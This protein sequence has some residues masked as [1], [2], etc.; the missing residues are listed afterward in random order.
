MS[1][2]YTVYNLRLDMDSDLHAGG[3]SSL[4]NFYNTLDKGRREL[5][6]NVRPEE[7]IRT[8]YL[9]QALYP[10]VDRYAVPEDMKY[11]DIIQLHKL[12][13]YRNVDTMDHP[14]QLVF[15]RRFDQKRGGAKNVMSI[16]YENGVKYARVFSPAG[17]RNDFEYRL[18][19]DCNSLTDN[20]SWNVGGNVVNLRLDE[21]NYVVKTGSLSFDINNSSTTGFLEN[22]TLDHFS[23]KDFLQKGAAFTWLDLPLPQEMISIKL[24]LGSNA[25]NLLTDLYESTV[26][27]PHDNN[28]F[29][30]GWNLLKYMLN[31][32]TTVGTPNPDDLLYIR[33]DFT[34][35]GQPIPNCHI[36]SIVARKGAVYQATYNGSYIF[37]DATTKAF[38]KFATADSDIIIAE[39]DTYNVLRYECT[40]AAQKEIYG[41]AGAAKSDVSDIT[42]SLQGAYKVFKMEHP[43]EALL[44][45]D[46]Y[47]VYGNIYDGYS[48]DIMPG[49]DYGRDSNESWN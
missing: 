33:F 12:S 37:M 7:L 16:G 25:G 8:E 36:D 41:S 43:S 29:A 26:N 49:D 15:R 19:H 45:T 42:N 11:K 47:R 46:S 24:T 44:D 20:G 32:L 2:Y 18:I 39:E 4:Q 35:T 38:K 30:T 21:L 13:G 1:N 22:F 27:Q 48:D 14:M 5:I 10:Q 17:L 6:R 9:E 40:L 23:L 34:T 3:T 28:V 31:N